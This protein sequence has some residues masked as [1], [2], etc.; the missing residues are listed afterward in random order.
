[1]K[2][3]DDPDPDLRYL[4]RR[5]SNYTARDLRTLRYRDGVFVVDAAEGASGGVVDHLCELSR[6]TEQV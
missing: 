6:N 3:D 4:A 1:M 5:K 2:V